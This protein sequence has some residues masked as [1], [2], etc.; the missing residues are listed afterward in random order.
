MILTRYTI[1][2][3]LAQARPN[4]SFSLNGLM[5]LTVIKSIVTLHDIIQNGRKNMCMAAIMK[6]RILV[7]IQ[8]NLVSLKC[9]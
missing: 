7:L 1:Y 5:L 8:T 4:Y 2:V 6:V 9:R 3:G